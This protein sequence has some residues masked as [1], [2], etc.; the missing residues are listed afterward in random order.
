MVMSEPPVAVDPETPLTEA[1]RTMLEH[2]IGAVIVLEGGR[3]VGIV[4]RSDALEALLAVVE[5]TPLPRGAS[6]PR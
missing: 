6:A 3:P 2:R 5:S 4:T 1:V